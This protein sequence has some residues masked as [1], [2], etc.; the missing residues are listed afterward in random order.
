MKRQLLCKALGC[1]HLIFGGGDLEDLFLADYFFGVVLEPDFIFLH[2]F[3][4]QILFLANITGE[5]FFST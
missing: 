4:G 1:D 3:D 5:I 2:S